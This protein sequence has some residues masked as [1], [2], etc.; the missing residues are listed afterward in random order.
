MLSTAGSYH[1]QSGLPLPFGSVLPGMKLR[2]GGVD[3]GAVVKARV[4]VASPL[5]GEVQEVPD[6]SEQV[7]A[8]LADVRSHP[9]MR[10]VEVAQGAVSVAGKNGN[11]RVLMP[12]AVFSA[13]VIL[14][15]VAAGAEETQLVP[16]SRT[17]EGAQS[18]DISGRDNGNPYSTADSGE[19]CRSQGLKACVQPF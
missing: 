8:A 11:G 10:G 19:V 16:A 5:R 14:E 9:R 18:G 7:D 4:P 3:F 12:F 6:G 2:G 15:S 13:E 1:G 17:S